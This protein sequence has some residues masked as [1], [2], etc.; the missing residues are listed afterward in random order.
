MRCTYGI[1]GRENHQTYGQ[2]RCIYTVLANPISERTSSADAQKPGPP[3]SRLLCT[4]WKQPLVI[5]PE[6]EWPSS[7]CA[8]PY[9]C[10]TTKP[11]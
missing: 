10:D 8:S 2:I 11:R 7:T 6:E 1:F 4:S 3:V 5:A 9:V